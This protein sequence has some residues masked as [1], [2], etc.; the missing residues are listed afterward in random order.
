MRSKLLKFIG[1]ARGSADWYHD[2]G[3]KNRN[4]I[5]IEERTVPDFDGTTTVYR[6]NPWNSGESE[7]YISP[8]CSGMG[9]T[10]SF[11]KATGYIEAIF[12]YITNPANKG[13]NVPDL[14]SFSKVI[15]ERLEL[16]N[17][18]WLINFSDLDSESARSKC[19]SI[20][21][22]SGRLA[23]E[24]FGRVFKNVYRELPELYNSYITCVAIDILKGNLYDVY[25]SNTEEKY[26]DVETA[27]R[28]L[29]GFPI[30]TKKADNPELRRIN[31]IVASYCA[32]I[33]YEVPVDVVVSLMEQLTQYKDTERSRAITLRDALLTVR[34]KPDIS[35][36]VL[37]D[38]SVHN[39]GV[40][41]LFNM[42]KYYLRIDEAPKAGDVV[43]EDDGYRSVNYG[44]F[45][46]NRYKV[47][48]SNKKYELVAGDYYEIRRLQVGGF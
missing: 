48:E 1:S 3:Y 32:S 42:V 35:K 38:M 8:L 17:P 15:G 6:I 29:N 43:W 26:Y 46:S 25:K 2:V 34:L 21:S 18:R 41:R 22:S 5:N 36:F 37:S 33:M 7:L 45:Q 11:I 13:N 9:Y 39:S 4:R 40:E 31:L 47:D 14:D 27:R 10:A 30:R 12:E 44:F 24:N 20:V 19:E 23:R 28:I 16:V